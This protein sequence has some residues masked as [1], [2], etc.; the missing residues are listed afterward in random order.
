MDNWQEM[1]ANLTMIVLN[2]DHPPI[3]PLFEFC[4]SCACLL[5]L[6]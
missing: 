1:F 2:R 6:T 5:V 4:N 3:F